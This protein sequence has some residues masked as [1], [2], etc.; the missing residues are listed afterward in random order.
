ME[1]YDDT[2]NS[3]IEKIDLYLKGLFEEKKILEIYF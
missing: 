3:R 2:I 1:A